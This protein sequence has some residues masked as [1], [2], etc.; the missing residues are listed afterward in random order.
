MAKVTGVALGSQPLSI[1]HI[2]EKMERMKASCAS[3]YH[4]RMAIKLTSR[5]FVL[6]RSQ[7]MGACQESPR[8]A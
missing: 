4:H 1:R 6:Q 7:M 8:L 2:R 3:L 5:A